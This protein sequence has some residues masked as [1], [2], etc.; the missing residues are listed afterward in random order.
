VIE[1]V[2]REIIDVDQVRDAILV[3]AKREGDEVTGSKIRHG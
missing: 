2:E 3:A 1:I